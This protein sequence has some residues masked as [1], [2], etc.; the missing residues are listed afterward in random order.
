[1][2]Q[3]RPRRGNSTVIDDGRTIP[4]GQVLKA[5]ICIIGA[6]PA[7][8]T[9]ALELA[10]RGKDVLML[11]AGGWHAD[12]RTQGDL[13]GEIGSAAHA[14]LTECRSRQFGGTSAVWSGRCLPL[15]AIDFEARDYVLSSGWPIGWEEIARYYPQANRYCHAGACAYAWHEA[16]PH[17]PEAAGRDVQDGVLVGDRIERWSLPTHFGRHYRRPLERSRAIRVLLHSVGLNLNLDPEGRRVVALDAAGAP[18][19]HFR[20]VAET[21]IIAAGGL[22]TTRLL[23]ASNQQD[24]RGTGNRDGLLGRYYMGHVFGSVAEIQFLKGTGSEF[25]L[26]LRDADGVFCRRR[27]WLAPATQRREKLLNTSFWTTNPPAA[28]PAHGDGILSAAYIALS[29]PI[30]RDRIAPPAIQKMFRGDQACSSWWLHVRNVLHQLP[31]TAAYGSRYFLK[32]LFAKRRIPALFVPSPNGR[33][34]LFYHAEQAPNRESRVKLAGSRDRFGMQRI[35]VDLRYQAQD[36]DSVVRAHEVVAEDLL[37]QGIATVHFKKADVR[38]HI[39]E[40]ARDGF[41]QIGTTRMASSERH[42]VVDEDCRV[43]GI[44]NL[45]VCGSS[46]FPTAGHANPM[47][48]IVALAVRLAHRL[49]QHP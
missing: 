18:G 26:F 43:H 5:G 31:E 40:Q 34:D 8:V 39:L 44:A 17:D 46:V 23:L 10:K 49:E 16:F 41:H 9:L 1:M 3:Q 25:Q 47:L 14:P 19:R 11:E 22:E 24:P 6:G 30:L 2:V 33:Y 48:T 35:S 28:D 27:L 21:F 36:I 29:L 7:G 4:L 12:R 38:R 45:Y 20:V 37:R 32:R 42:G 13:E 15:D